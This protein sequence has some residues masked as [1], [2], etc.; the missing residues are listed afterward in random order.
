[1]DQ[2]AVRVELSPYD[3]EAPRVFAQ[4][5]RTIRGSVSLPIAVEHVG[6]TAVPGL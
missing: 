4:L 1:M 3:P 5:Q 2:P 6:S